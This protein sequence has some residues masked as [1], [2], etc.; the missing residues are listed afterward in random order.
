MINTLASGRISLK[1]SSLYMFLQGISP[2][3][4]VL[5]SCSKESAGLRV[6]N[7]KNFFILGF[8]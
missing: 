4:I 6:C 2:Q 5:E 8:L 1:S 7:E 3:A